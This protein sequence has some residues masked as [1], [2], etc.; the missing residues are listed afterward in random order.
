M[1]LFLIHFRWHFLNMYKSVFRR[2]I[3]FNYSTKL[4]LHFSIIFL[5]LYSQDCLIVHDLICI[6]L[7]NLLSFTPCIWK[8]SLK[9]VN[10]CFVSAVHHPRS[11]WVAILKAFFFGIE[12][13]A[14]SLILHKLDFPADFMSPGPCSIIHDR[15]HKGF[16][17][18]HINTIWHTATLLVFNVKGGE[19]LLS[20]DTL[21]E[22]SLC[23]S[24]QRPRY[25]YR[26]SKSMLAAPHWKVK[27]ERGLDA[28][29]ICYTLVFSL[30]AANLHL[31]HHSCTVLHIFW[32]FSSSGAIR[33]ISSA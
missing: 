20:S 24:S 5:T 4:K 13:I 31:R 22:K 25:R 29:Q 12:K 33:A 18:F 2:I 21:Y 11:P 1:P 28:E 19:S 15:V 10:L 16:I 26:F 8:K 30:L 14:S 9:I 23:S 32:S 17:W 7:I 27:V 6:F 3:W